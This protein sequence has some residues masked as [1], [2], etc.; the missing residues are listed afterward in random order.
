VSLGEGSE[1][2]AIDAASVGR[3]VVAADPQSVVVDLASTVE[4]DV[5]VR[6]G[7]GV[8]LE[9]ATIGRRV[10]IRNVAGSVFVARSR[11]NGA[12]EVADNRVVDGL[13]VTGTVIGGDAVVSRNRGPGGKQVTENEVA[14]T[15]TC[16]Q[17]DEPFIGFPNTAER[18]E[19]QCI[20]EAPPPAP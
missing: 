14:G 7:S 17:N 5:S 19:G 11:V 1:F 6:G 4:R 9:E 8:R 2:E 15:L 12:L 16:L 13:F 18:F 3:D 20:A 10:G